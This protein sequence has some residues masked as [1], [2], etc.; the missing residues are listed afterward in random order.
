MPGAVA[1]GA[2]SGVSRAPRQ[3]VHGLG[4]RADA[5][6]TPAIRPARAAVARGHLA[7]RGLTSHRHAAADAARRLRG[8]TERRPV[9]PLAGGIHQAACC[10]PPRS[11][12]ARW[13]RPSGRGGHL[14]R[15][16]IEGAGLA[17]LD[18]PRGGRRQFDRRRMIR[19][20]CHQCG[21]SLREGLR[22]GHQAAGEGGVLSVPPG[23][24]EGTFVGSHDVIGHDL[25]REAL[26]VTELRV[27]VGA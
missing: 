5:K 12:H 23:W 26:V 19:E 2:S 17:P 25:P 8:S 10:A 16:A 4:P 27:G 6:P 24:R 22:P 13:G 15:C 9:T 11:L 7:A 18:R 14:P 3:H 20:P 21:K 1:V